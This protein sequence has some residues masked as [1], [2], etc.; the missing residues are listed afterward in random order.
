MTIQNKVGLML[1]FLIATL[2]TNASAKENVNCYER[3]LPKIRQVICLSN[4][5]AKINSTI[6]KRNLLCSGVISLP[7]RS[8]DNFEM[9]I[10]D[11]KNR[12]QCLDTMGNIKGTMAFSKKT[13]IESSSELV[14]LNSK[15]KKFVYSKLNSTQANLELRIKSYQI[16]GTQKAKPKE[17]SAEASKTFKTLFAC[18][19]VDDMANVQYA[20]ALFRQILGG[21]DPNDR[22]SGFSQM[23]ESIGG[24]I[25]KCNSMLSVPSQTKQR[26]DTNDSFEY[27]GTISR[28]RYSGKRVYKTRTQGAASS[29]HKGFLED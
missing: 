23:V 22:Y 21:D 8:S 29:A 17:K 20:D 2:A 18:F 13:C 15:N 14:C 1:W 11:S 25:T 3:D 19:G 6:K 9:S 27:V 5:G 26:L 28:G 4:E 10:G 16:L 12:L 24:G 7:N